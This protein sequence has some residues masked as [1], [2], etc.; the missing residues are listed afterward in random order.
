MQNS[1]TPFHAGELAVQDQF[2]VREAVQAYAPRMIR[3]FMP[4]Q[5]REFYTA[6]PYFFMASVDKDGA[7]WASV[8]WGEIGFVQSPSPT[9]LTISAGPLEKDPLFSSLTEGAEVGMIGIQFHTRR[10]NRV[11]GRI[12]LVRDGDFSIEVTQSFGN[13]PQ[14]IQ[15][16]EVRPVE[17]YVQDKVVSQLGDALSE[18][19]KALV[20]RADTFFIASASGDLGQDEKHGVDMSHRGGEA[21]F[22]KVLKDGS[23]LF[24]D[25]SGNNIYNTLGNI[26]ANPQAGL[27]FIDFE[28]RDILQLSG[29][30]EMILPEDSPY[31]YDEALKY[32][33]ITPRRVIRHKKAVPYTFTTP[34]MSPFVP[35]QARWSRTG[36]LPALRG[37]QVY[38]E[39]M[40][41][42]EEAAGI[43]SFY[44]KPEAGNARPYAPGQHL[45]VSLMVDGKLERRTYTL[46][47][48]PNE[49]VYR[50]TVKREKQGT[51]SRF[52]HDELRIG[53]TL[54]T[55]KPAGTFTLAREDAPVVL[56]S[57]GVGITPMMAMAESL[58]EGS[59]ADIPIAFIHAS[60]TPSVT[61][62]LPLMRRW[63]QENPSAE[64][65]LRFSEAADR[66]LRTIPGASAGY[67]DGRWLKRQRL[68]KNADYYLCGP[69]G[70]M[71]GV[72]DFLLSEGIDDAQIHFEAFG[73]ASLKRQQQKPTANYRAQKVEF[74]AS[75]KTIVWDA[76]TET[77]LEAAENNG[78][79]APFSCRSGSCG[80][81]AVRRLNG[82]VQ[83]ETPPAYPVD[84]DEILLCCA[85]PV[86]DETDESLL[87]DL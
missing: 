87:L 49:H 31:H 51:V 77:L 54:I 30:A 59:N 67:A 46:S 86:S 12:S 9:M 40:D 25:F 3:R 43:K 61:P 17:G 48:A 79:E 15:G 4:D 14:Y 29:H 52:L 65:S 56:L 72:Y 7:P 63:R 85:V 57:A 64:I 23:I 62:F 70:F 26:H 76:N 74:S 41:I 42:V 34:Q 20:E 84:N 53:D 33:R 36:A 1:S 24:P 81:C 37:D 28:S 58:F 78:I 80:S 66:D 44:L 38:S 8:L 22:V 45:P 18:S 75:K 69:Q 2:G 47:A 10:R 6:L 73:P 68:P 13:C 19:D 83:Y 71:Q 16:R 82:R 39:V 35:Y 55:A 50:I 11:N 21:G 27:L 32:V 5:H 60:R